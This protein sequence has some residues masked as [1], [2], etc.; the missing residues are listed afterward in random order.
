MKLHDIFSSNRFQYGDC[1]AEVYRIA[2]IAIT[3]NIPI[4]IVRG[5]AWIPAIGDP[6]EEDAHSWIEINGEIHD[7]TINQFDDQIEYHNKHGSIITHNDIVYNKEREYTP[8]E[9][10]EEYERH[11][12]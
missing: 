9:F 8:E 11:W 12:R 6:D 4:V 5:L 10:I 1:D 2:K 3:Q 7:P